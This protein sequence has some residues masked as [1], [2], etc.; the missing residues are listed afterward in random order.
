MFLRKFAA[1]TRLSFA[2]A[3]M[4]Y[5][6]ALK[7]ASSPWILNSSGTNPRSSNPEQVLHQ[8][9]QMLFGCTFTCL[10]TFN[11]LTLAVYKVREM[12]KLAPVCQW[13]NVPVCQEREL[14]LIE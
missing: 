3:V 8:M 2:K 11:W 7:P 10:G 9:R 14:N 5:I 13:F 1:A 6:S 12:S 4:L